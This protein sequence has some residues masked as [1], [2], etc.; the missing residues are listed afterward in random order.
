MLKVKL[1]KAKNITAPFFIIA[2]FNRRV[3]IFP[4]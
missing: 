1:I 3:V 4:S 2:S